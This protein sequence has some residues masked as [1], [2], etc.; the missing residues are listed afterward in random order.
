MPTLGKKMA[1]RQRIIITGRHF[2]MIEVLIHQEDRK[3][4]NTCVYSSRTPPA[5]TEYVFKYTWNIV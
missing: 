3:I 2:I 5:T 4:V 1:F